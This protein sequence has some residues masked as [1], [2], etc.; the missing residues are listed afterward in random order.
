M[1]RTATNLNPDGC[2]ESVWNFRNLSRTPLDL[3]LVGLIGMCGVSWWVTLD[4]ERRPVRFGG[5]PL[6]SLPHS[7]HICHIGEADQGKSSHFQILSI[8]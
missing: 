7:S 5:I 1:C 2:M 8:L 6:N 3:S 4:G